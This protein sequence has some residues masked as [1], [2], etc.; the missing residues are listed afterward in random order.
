MLNEKKNYLDGIIGLGMGGS[1]I[2]KSF[3]E[4]R[5]IPYRNLNFSNTDLNYTDFQNTKVFSGDGTGR[6]LKVGKEISSLHKDEIEKYINEFSN[7]KITI[8]ICVGLGGGSGSGM[9]SIVI[10]TLLENKDR[11]IVL[12]AS[13]PDLKMEGLPATNNYLISLQEIIGSFLQQMISRITIIIIENDYCLKKYPSDNGDY[14]SGVNKNLVKNTHSIFDTINHNNGSSDRAF[15]IDTEEYKRIFFNGGLIDFKNFTFKTDN[16]LDEIKELSSKSLGSAFNSKLYTLSTAKGYL[17]SITFPMYF[18]NKKNLSEIIN[19]ISLKISRITK[20]NN[21]LLGVN[22]SAKLK[23]PKIH[24]I[25]YGLDFSGTIQRKI[26]S[27][28]KAI[29]KVRSRGKVNKLDLTFKNKK[30]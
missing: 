18:F 5:K 24:L 15:I 21:S 26:M 16:A 29:D 28:E 23:Y 14:Y 13:L 10:K 7:N 22:Y 6:N 2:A 20:I 3:S 4:E 12:Y 19:G 9:L 1:R 25:V 17:L 30:F 11:K 8:G 27:T